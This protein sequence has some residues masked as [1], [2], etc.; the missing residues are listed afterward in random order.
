[1]DDRELLRSSIADALAEI[2]DLKRVHRHVDGLEDLA[3][4]LRARAGEL[5]WLAIGVSPEA[6]GLGQGIAGAVL[7]AEELGRRLAPGPFIPTLAAA[8][9]LDEFAPADIKQALV[10]GVISGARGVAIPAEVPAA[11]DGAE[12]L[13]LGD[14]TG[15]A[16][17]LAIATPGALRLSTPTGSSRDFIERPGWD[18]TRRLWDLPSQTEVLCDLPEQASRR[19]EIIANLLAAADSL[20]AM[21]GVFGQ[22]VEYLK[23]REQFGVK[24][25]SFQAL[26]HRA[27]DITAQIELNNCLLE[28]AVE[29]AGEDEARAAFW[30]TACKASVTDA[31][32]FVAQE[33]LQLH[34]GIGFTWEYD[35]HLYLKRA[36]L[37]QAL[38]RDNGRLRDRCFD[39]LAEAAA[40]GERLMELA[41]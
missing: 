40:R 15:K 13:L 38:V 4:E 9:I 7:L 14:L 41:S 34:G 11:V 27:A 19:L 6:G 21:K 22:T 12:G 31:A 10:P 1:M 36:R 8:Q 26:K 33:C 24:I 20:G 16:P 37:N 5:G 28:Q 2:C 29:A 18:R 35:C 3:T 39:G 17:L 30:S 25:G 32:V 23:T